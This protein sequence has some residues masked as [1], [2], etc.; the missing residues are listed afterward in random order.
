MNRRILSLLIFLLMLATVQVVEG[1]VQVAVTGTI[2]GAT[3]GTVQFK[4]MPWSTGVHYTVPVIGTLAN[5]TWICGINGSGAVVNLLLSGPCLLWGNDVI[6]PGNTTY[7]VVFQPNGQQ[8]NSVALEQ[9]TGNTYSLNSPV[10]GPN[11][12]IV[13]QY[14]TIT[15][16]PIAVNLV[17]VTPHTFNIGSAGL[18][19]AAAYIDQLFASNLNMP[20]TSITAVTI[21]NRQFCPVGSTFSTGFTAA[22]ALLPSTG[23]IVDC[24]NLQG[25]QTLA[26]DVFTGQTKPLTVIW[27][28]GTTTSAVSLTIPAT[29]TVDFPAGSILSQAMATTATFNGE[30]RGTLSQHFAGSGTIVFT[31][32]S[33]VS[34]V[35]PEWWGAIG[36]GSTD[37]S[38]AINAACA[39]IVDSGAVSFRSAAT[40]LSTAQ[41]LIGK[42]SASVCHNFISKGHT[43]LKF[44]VASHSTDL[45]VAQGYNLTNAYY[46][47][48]FFPIHIA[49]FD[50]LAQNTGRDG[51]LL[52]DS[53]HPV[54]ENIRVLQPYRNGVSL[55]PNTNNWIENPYFH[56]VV[57]S[58]AGHNCFYFATLN[59][60]TFI[61]D[62]TYINAEC[63]G[64]GINSVTLGVNAGTQPTQ[65]GASIEVISKGGAT[66]GDID[67]HTFIAFTVDAG[68]NFAVANASQPNP[69]AVFFAD[70]Q[71]A[72][73]IEG[74]GVAGSNRNFTMWRFL[75][76]R[77]ED[78]AIGGF[79]G[80]ICW[81][82]QSASVT[83]P[84]LWIEGADGGNY[85]ALTA[86][87]F[88]QS[89]GILS[90]SAVQP[91]A[92]RN[93]RWGGAI[94]MEGGPLTLNTTTAGT[95]SAFITNAGAATSIEIKNTTGTASD[96]YLVTGN[97]GNS[98]SGAAI[99]FLSITAGVYQWCFDGS[100]NLVPWSDDGPSLGTN[101]HRVHGLQV[102]T[103]TSTFASAVSVTSGN[104]SV[105]SGNAVITGIVQ[106]SA[107]VFS[108]LPACVGGTA[109]A[110]R[111]VTDS[112]TNTWGAVITGSGANP[113]LAYCDGT[114]W[115]VMGK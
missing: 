79:T 107:T 76:P 16:S 89:D 15:T 31:A 106:P 91:G 21:N 28:M 53:D 12:K 1:Q 67:G 23:G 66:A 99:C 17:P 63:R 73:V 95:P 80:G 62:G 52:Q 84:N 108:G 38:A 83:T 75:N 112:T 24:S 115:T 94:D 36:D 2:V 100:G 71:A 3:S 10:F 20:L 26:S 55:T 19:Y 60:N 43:V 42:G 58:K 85:C 39:S 51:L 40:Y 74:A 4:L 101:T 81:T 22:A 98:V 46:G 13:P 65:L 25:A 6:S 41:L 86:S 8:T 110:M 70:G 37:D 114:N 45:I 57:V 96:W 50:I 54:L 64:F 48:Q 68:S 109:G 104:L 87:P 102:G 56:N 33:H 97:P 14:Q 35:Y 29:M 105:V 32:S 77:V 30:V 72:Q 34:E 47:I 111:G 82:K 88:A 61:N 9:I 44:N 7:T 27:P 113:V 49:G 78:V 93:M 59:A 18:P 90:W 69:D 92:I 5:Q 103:G 11:V